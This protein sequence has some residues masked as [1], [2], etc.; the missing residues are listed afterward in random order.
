MKKLR[1][2][3]QFVKAVGWVG[4]FLGPILQGQLFTA[5]NAKEFDR[6][7][8]AV[9]LILPIIRATVD[10]YWPNRPDW[11][12]DTDGILRGRR[13][14]LIICSETRCQVFL[15]KLPPARHSAGAGSRQVSG[16]GQ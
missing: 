8:S 5:A 9:R 10:A 16:A 6:F 15:R 13:R 2:R 7:L 14:G 1:R 11:I 4:M 12:W 3:L